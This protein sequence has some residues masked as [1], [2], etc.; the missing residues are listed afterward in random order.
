MVDALA[1]SCS[2]SDQ[3]ARVDTRSPACQPPGER[4]PP[5][6]EAQEAQRRRQFSHRRD[7]YMTRR[8]RRRGRR[9]PLKEWGFSQQRDERLCRKLQDMHARG[10]C[11]SVKSVWVVRKSSPPQKHLQRWMCHEWRLA[12]GRPGGFPNVLVRGFRQRAAPKPCRVCELGDDGKHNARGHYH[13]E[14]AGIIGRGR[15]QAF[16]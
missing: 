7:V 11:A 4:D 5:G 16:G 15:V 8:R 10:A 13:R 9:S 14:V 3:P 12:T 2:A 1:V 6:M